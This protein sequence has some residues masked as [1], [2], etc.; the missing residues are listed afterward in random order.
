MAQKPEGDKSNWR[1]SGNEVGRWSRVSRRIHIDA[2]F[3]N[4]SAPQPCGQSLFLYLITSP[5]CTAIPGLFPAREEGLA[6]DLGWPLEGFRE[7]FLELL[8]E[9]LAEADWKAGLVWLKKAAKHDPPTS[10]NA[11]AGWAKVVSDV[12]PECYL[13]GR[14]LEGIRSQV[15]EVMVD[16]SAFIAAFDKALPKGLLEGLPKGLPEPLP[17][18]MPHSGGR[19]QDAGGRTQEH[20]QEE[21]TTSSGEPDVPVQSPLFLTPTPTAQKIDC[22][23]EVAAHYVAVM[24][25]GSRWVFSDQRRRAVKGRLKQ[26]YT[27]DQ[28]KQAVDGCKASPYHQGGNPDGK[29][30]D[31]LELI[32]RDASKVDS[33]I[34]QLSAKPQAWGARG[35]AEPSKA[36]YEEAERKNALAPPEPEIDYAQMVRE[37]RMHPDDVPRPEP[38]EPA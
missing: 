20:E 4:L 38:E 33:F 37:G 23:D 1:T 7:G 26:G 31:D 6:A 27:V 17:E 24:G 18:G 29:I 11:V 14:A 12:L 16:P 9:G 30:W 28:L 19:R 8:R 32:C 34:S 35:F 25:K 10:P 22:E 13:L 5:H 36:D 15:C 3:R 21:E 2:R